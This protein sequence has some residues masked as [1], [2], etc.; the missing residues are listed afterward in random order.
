V[1]V[2]VSGVCV[3]VFESCVHVCLYI[4]VCV[5][6]CACVYVFECAQEWPSVLLSCAY[7]GTLTCALKASVSVSNSL[8]LDSSGNS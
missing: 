8:R 2:C 4:C 7:G 1:C 5:R 3:C 6:V